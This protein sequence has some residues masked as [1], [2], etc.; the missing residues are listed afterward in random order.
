MPSYSL[1]KLCHS[2]Q[3]PA[4]DRHRAAGDAEA[5][6]GLFRMLLSND[7][8]GHVGSFLNRRT[9]EQQLPPN[10]RKADIDSLPKTPGVYYFKDSK[11]SVIYVGK[12]VNVK[13][14]VLSHFTGNK[15]GRQRQE[16]LKNVFSVSC[17][18]KTSLAG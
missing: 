6:T 4:T 16:F 18:D 12:A 17:G 13:K 5:T 7:Q 11:G 1:G 15:F 10:L 9:S 14:R 3:I 2:L 8:E